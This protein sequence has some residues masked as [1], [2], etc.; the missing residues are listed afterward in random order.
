MCAASSS[1]A[2]LTL[3]K[4]PDNFSQTI[5]LSGVSTQKGPIRGGVENEFVPDTGSV[6]APASFS[7]SLTVFLSDGYP[8]AAEPILNFC[9]GVHDTKTSWPINAGDLSRWR[10]LSGTLSFSQELCSE[11]ASTCTSHESRLKSFLHVHIIRLQPSSGAPNAFSPLPAPL[12]SWKAIN[13]SQILTREMNLSRTRLRRHKRPIRLCAAAL[14]TPELH[15]GRRDV[16]IR[17]LTRYAPLC[18]RVRYLN[19]AMARQNL[20]VIFTLGG[21][22]PLPVSVRIS[23]CPL[24][25]SVYSHSLKTTRKAA[26]RSFSPTLV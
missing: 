21:L 25:S 18:S 11:G 15:H 17:N 1:F 5:S 4:T 23:Q 14:H 12:N 2:A 19:T 24:P 16:P 22:P 3:T 6:C 13:T 7:C 20:D 8:S 26:P 10:A 9:R